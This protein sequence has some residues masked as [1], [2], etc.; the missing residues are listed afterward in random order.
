MPRQNPRTREI[1]ARAFAVEVLGGVREYPHIEKEALFAHAMAYFRW[2]A[3]LD[4]EDSIAAYTREFAYQHGPLMSKLNPG[5][6]EAA[7]VT[8]FVANGFHRLPLFRKEDTV[9]LQGETLHFSLPCFP[10]PTESRDHTFLT[11]WLCWLELHRH[12]TPPGDTLLY[13]WSRDLARHLPENCGLNRDA[14]IEQCST[15]FSWCYTADYDQDM[16]VSYLKRFALEQENALL[17][18]DEPEVW[19]AHFLAWFTGCVLCRLD[20]ENAS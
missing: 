16:L 8:W 11:Q 13:R 20:W 17:W 12:E 10:L 19:D 18:L 15:F 6:Q 1:R 7:F 5:L 9:G 2:L 14:L 4:E 3:S